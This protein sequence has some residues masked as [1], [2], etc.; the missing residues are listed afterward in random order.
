MAVPDFSPI[1]TTS[2]IV[3]PV[4]GTHSNVVESYLPYGLYVNANLPDSERN[5]WVTGAVSQVSYTYRMLGG[6]VLDIELTEQDVYAAYEDACLE[7]ST[8][9][10][11]HQAKNS[12]PNLLGQP[13]GTFDHEGEHLSSPLSSS[14]SG[15][16]VALKFPKF[17]FSYSRRLSDAV[18]TA[19]GV[20]GFETIYSASIALTASKQDYDL[21]EI[22]EAQ[23]VAGG[24]LFSDKINNR[25]IRIRRVFYKSPQATWRFYGFYG[26]LVSIGNLS[27]YGQYADD[28]SY[29]IVP[30]WQNK[31]QAAAYE[32][33]LRVRTS[34]YSYMLRNNKLRIYPPPREYLNAIWVEFSVDSNPILDEDGYESGVDGVNNVNT[35]PFSNIPYK[36]INA[37]GKHW[38]RRY[39]LATCKCILAQN[40]GKFQTIP[41]PG[42]S[43]TLNH[44]DLMSQCKDERRELKEELNKTLDELTYAKIS[45]TRANETDNVNRTLNKM[46]MFIYMG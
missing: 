41:I 37:I 42:E 33:A 34:H 17:Q 30:V 20:G 45:E 3:L 24:Q 26:S 2:R 28:H 31:A 15:G 32:D 46:P 25:K 43:V 23:D 6:A 12:L 29:Q 38:I 40:R 21:Q 19:V 36:N 1:P 18:G 44:S 8:V 35:V 11:L 9:I 39:A 7:Y 10:N 22:I 5:E 14:L 13:T 16:N 27:T 4:T